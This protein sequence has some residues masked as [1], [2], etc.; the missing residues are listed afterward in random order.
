MLRPEL[1]HSFLAQADYSQY[2]DSLISYVVIAAILILPFLLG[3]SLANSLRMPTYA[4]RIGLIIFSIVLALYFL[5]PVKDEQGKWHIPM[6]YGVD[7]SGGTILVYELKQ[8][9]VTESAAAGDS[10]TDPVTGSTVARSANN[11]VAKELI[12]PLVERLN[13][14]GT[15]DIVVRPYGEQQIEIIVPNTEQSEVEQIQ[16]SIETAGALRFA[17]V[18]NTR[19]HRGLISQAQLMAESPTDRRR[20]EIRN[21]DG[22]LIGL[23]AEVDRESNGDQVL[24]VDVYGDIIRDA[25]TKE[26][27]TNAPRVGREEFT[28]WMKEQKIEAIEVLMAVDPLF[29]ITGEELA[30]VSN[31]V[32]ERGGN[33]VNFTSRI[34]RQTVSMR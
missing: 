17:I 21:P 30:T 20:T 11:S 7:L 24:R 5:R 33:A 6:K 31:G 18:A 27:L 8:D 28:Q 22:Q 12:Q 3:R 25:T 13:P 14:S 15:N 1:F 34:Y 10:A 4:T 19:D 9:A 2:A 29:D 32:D 26:I 16:R 23:W